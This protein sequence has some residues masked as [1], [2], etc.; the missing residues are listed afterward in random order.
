MRYFIL[1]AMALISLSGLSTSAKAAE[2]SIGI[3]DVQKILSESKAA[4]HMQEQMEKEQK[5]FLDALKKK[6][7]ALR[8][9]EKKILE[10]A[11]SMSK[12]ELNEKKQNFAK[13]FQAS[14]QFAQENKQRLD[15]ALAEGMQKLRLELFETVEDVSDKGGY[16]LILPKQLIFAGGE[17]LDITDET[18][19]ALDKSLKKVDL[20]FKK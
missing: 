3:L 20:D 13:D 8:A 16:T 4:Q 2:A 1:A 17:T 19:K 6:E 12:D 11:S 5:S 14:R 15:R 18:L 7:E 9:R 10:N